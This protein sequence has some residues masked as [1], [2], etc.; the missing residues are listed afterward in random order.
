MHISLS[1]LKFLIYVD[2]GQMEGSVSQNLYLGPSFL[3]MKSRKKCFEKCQKVT[4][5]LS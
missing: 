5:F 3:F 2:E 1:Y 4:R